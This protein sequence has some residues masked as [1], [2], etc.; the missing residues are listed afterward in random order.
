MNAEPIVVAVEGCCHGELDSIYKTI[1]Q[2]EASGSPKVELLVACGD[3]QCVK[4]LLDLQCLAVPEKYRKM[5]SFQR[6]FSG[7]VV[8]PVLTI[9]IGGNHEASNVLQ[10][11]YYGGWICPN[12]Y[13]LGFAGVVNYK[14]L[15]IGGISGIYNQRHYHLGHYEK[16]PY[17]KGDL[18]SVYH[19][20]ELEV[21]R[22]AHL[23]CRLK[24]NPLDIIISHDWP[25][26]IWDYGNSK[27]LLRRKPYFEE[28][29][30]TGKL[31]SPPLMSLLKQL[32][33]TYWFAAHLHLK[34][35]AI[36]PHSHDEHVQTSLSMSS[37]TPNAP[38]CIPIVNCNK[39][40]TKFLS[41]DKC[42]PGRE[43]LQ[44]LKISTVG[45]SSID[46]AFHP[47]SSSSFLQ[48][49]ME[50]LAI[51]RKTHN[52]LSMRRG[53]VEMPLAVVPPSDEDIKEVKDIFL[54]LPFGERIPPRHHCSRGRN[55]DGS[56]RCEQT[57]ELFEMLGIKHLWMETS[58][59][60]VAVDNNIIARDRSI[61]LS[62]IPQHS[63]ISMSTDPDEIDLE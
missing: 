11:L 7:E 34:F 43:F 4:D 22:M 23:Q 56:A 33:P 49:D 59:T 39:K 35:T 36:V 47:I 55:D 42:E 46:N 48:Y 5:N 63:G 12:I 52:L 28:D 37:P 21:Y 38:Q 9:F 30:R 31:G 8:A 10:S 6:Y 58:A 2:A 18:H 57:D 16:P 14:G 53:V 1:A 60:G 45:P 27:D 19:L 51:L 17:S 32:K 54:N 20:R 13:F 15:R 29:I 61:P 62:F 3:F 25:Q 24:Q 50:W 44:I 26:G 41:L 40:S